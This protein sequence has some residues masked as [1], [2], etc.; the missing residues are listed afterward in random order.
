MKFTQTTDLEKISGLRQQFYQTLSGPLDGM[1]ESLYIGGADNYLI[2]VQDEEVGYCC[3]DGDRS[4]VQ[5]FLLPGYEGEMGR[6]VDVLVKESL[7]SSAK[8]SSIEPISFNACLSRASSCEVNTFCYAFS[9]VKMVSNEIEMEQVALT[10]VPEVKAYFKA[11]IGFDDTF[12]YT[13]NLVM[14]Q[15]LYWLKDGDEVIATGECRLS[16][17]QPTIA[18]VGVVVNRAYQGKGR[19]RKVL[20]W[21][22]G[23]A[24]QS[25]RQPVCSTTKEN[26]ASQKAIQGAG[27]HCTH[28]IYDMELS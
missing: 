8:L 28:V 4:M 11:Q 15:E 7:V 16:D 3:I 9:A 12:G 19:G 24:R 6:L 2:Q 21:L 1:W 20:K 18:D 22:A 17:T 10:D 13:Q 25:N 5:A 23:R 14:R 26:I 27:F